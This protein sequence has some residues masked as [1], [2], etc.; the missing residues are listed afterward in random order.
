[1]SKV[2]QALH[3]D[4]LSDEA[5]A[6]G[7]RRAAEAQLHGLRQEIQTQGLSST[8]REQRS[9]I[10]ELPFSG[11]WNPSERTE[12]I[13]REQLLQLQ[14]LCI[15]YYIYILSHRAECRYYLSIQ[16]KCNSFCSL[17]QGTTE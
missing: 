2:R 17:K 8:S 11:K 3:V 10:E 6:R 7:L 16:V 14:L 15:N 4:G 13:S 9:Q 1:M 12:P 5:S